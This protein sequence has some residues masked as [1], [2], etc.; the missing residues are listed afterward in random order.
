M[1]VSSERLAKSFAVLQKLTPEEQ[2]KTET[3]K[4]CRVLWWQ[5]KLDD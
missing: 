1:C 3:S 5:L 4:A 2:Q